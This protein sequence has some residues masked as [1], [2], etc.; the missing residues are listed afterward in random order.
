M[1]QENLEYLKEKLKF[2]GFDT[3]LNAALEKQIKAGNQ[4]FQL[5]HSMEI[6]GKKMD[7]SL[8]FRKSN[9]SERYFLNKYDAS[10][11]NPNPEISPK[12]H[13]F[14]NN[15]SVTAKEAFNLLEGRAVKKGMLNAD[16][17]PY[18]A[19]MQ[20]DFAEK[21]KNNNFKIESYHENYGFDSKEAL[22]KLPIKELQDP[23]KTEWMLKA[24]EKGNVYPVTMEKGGKEE[25]MYVSANPKFK[26]VNVYDVEMKMVKTNDLKLGKDQGKEVKQ[27][28]Q[29][30]KQQ[31]PKV[32][33]TPKEPKKGKGARM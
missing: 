23:T 7:F 17:E 5:P 9:T 27:D 13:T 25:I 26:S 11:Q 20:L 15:Q 18:Q 24:F 3:D 31:A 14:Y 32:K 2:T 6:E 30:E 28:Q 19:W 16:N 22:S 12:Q 29:E 33:N 1:D 21:D 10:L 8:H 4:A